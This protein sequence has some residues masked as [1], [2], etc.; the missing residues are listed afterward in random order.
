M[1]IIFELWEKGSLNL[2]FNHL[3]PVVSGKFDTSDLKSQR[4]AVLVKQ[5]FPIFLGDFPVH[6]HQ[7][8]HELGQLKQKSN[9][10]TLS[11]LILLQLTSIR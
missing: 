11:F 8:A 3:F 9:I 6:L 1:C 2:H 4:D 10:F 7:S 5:L